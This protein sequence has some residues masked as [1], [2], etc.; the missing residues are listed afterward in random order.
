MSGMSGGGKTEMVF[1]TI[2]DEFVEEDGLQ[3]MAAG[4]Q[5]MMMT[6]GVAVSFVA[7]ENNQMIAIANNILQVMEVRKFAQDMEQV[8]KVEY[9]KKIFR[10]Y[11]IS[12]EE[13]EKL[14]IEEEE[15]E[16]KKNAN[17]KTDL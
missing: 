17:K 5:E 3:R 13:R 8:L 7:V 15:K 6:G 2:R 4:Y 14:D 10:G 11:H 16:A 12:E 9:D 1:I